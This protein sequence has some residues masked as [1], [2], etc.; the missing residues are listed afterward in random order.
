[1]GLHYGWKLV[2]IANLI[3]VANLTSKIIEYLNDVK[4]APKECR[5]LKVE[6]SNL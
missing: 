2:V 1:M 4:D 5:Q 6:A 3:A